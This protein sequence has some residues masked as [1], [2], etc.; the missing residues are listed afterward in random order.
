MIVRCIWEHNGNDT[1]LYAENPAGAFARGASL[2]EAI[3]KMPQEICSFLKWQGSPAPRSVEIQIIQEKRSDLDICDADSNVLF[4]SEKQP[5]TRHEYEKLKTLVLRSA[6]DFEKL[7]QSIPDPNKSCL[8]ARKTFYGPIPRTAQEMYEHT[9]NVTAYYLGEIK[10]DTANGDNMLSAREAAFQKL[11][12]QPDYLLN[13][14]FSGS[15]GEEWTLRKVLRR[16][17]WHDRIHA[18][19]LYRMACK[20]FPDASI[21]NIFAFQF[22]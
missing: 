6:Q 7:Y 10:V 5:L 21:P 11:E 20:T 4:E 8:P 17:L 12:Q 9:K 14:I 19:A 3:A 16:F 15:Y 13:K 22:N 1:L 18:K 2:D